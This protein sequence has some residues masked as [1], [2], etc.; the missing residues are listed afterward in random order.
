M[1]AVFRVGEFIGLTAAEDWNEGRVLEA[2]GVLDNMIAI[3][4]KTG[5]RAR[6]ALDSILRAYS[7]ARLITG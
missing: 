5:I 3:S 1:V 6:K 4:R 7:R 2:S